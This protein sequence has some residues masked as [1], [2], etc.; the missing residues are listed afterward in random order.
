MDVNNP[1]VKLCI[2]GTQAEFRGQMNTAC[3]LYQQAWEAALDAY[4]ACIAAHYLAR[5]QADPAEKLRWNQ[6]ALDNANTVTDDRVREFYPSLY[7]NLGESHELLGNPQESHRYYELAARLG[8]PH[9][10]DVP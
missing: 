3:D 6:I 5:C 2:E 4:D 9:Q 8:F 1:V 7:L 10:P